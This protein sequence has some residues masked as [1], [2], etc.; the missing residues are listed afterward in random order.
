MADAEP[1]QIDA[2]GIVKRIRGIADADAET[3]PAATRLRA[4]ELL[5]RMQGLFRERRGPQHVTIV[6]LTP[7]LRLPAGEET[8]D[9]DDDNA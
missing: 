3:T 2:D 9:D 4:L 7:A 6:R 5:A 1:T 8:S